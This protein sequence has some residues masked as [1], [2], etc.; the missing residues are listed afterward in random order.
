VKKQH[1]DIEGLKKVIIDLQ[2]RISLLMSKIPDDKEK[3]S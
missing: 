2:N 3:L 1:G